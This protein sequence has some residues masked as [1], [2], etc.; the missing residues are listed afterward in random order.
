MYLNGSGSVCSSVSYP[1]QTNKTE[2]LKYNH[3]VWFWCFSS[4]QNQNLTMSAVST[5]SI[6]LVICHR[7]FFRNK[8][9]RAI[10][11]Y[12]SEIQTICSFLTQGENFVVTLFIEGQPIADAKGFKKQI[13]MKV[14]ESTLEFLTRVCYTIRYELSMYLLDSDFPQHT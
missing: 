14:A 2:L 10:E 11:Q 6:V 4:N 3:K 7:K 5:T 13:K 8:F 9:D 1:N 12:Q